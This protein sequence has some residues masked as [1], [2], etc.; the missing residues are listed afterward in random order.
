M[1]DAFNGTFFFELIFRSPKILRSSSSE[2]FKNKF[3][4][5]LQHFKQ[6]FI[7]QNIATESR[8]W[9]VLEI[10]SFYKNFIFI[11]NLAWNGKV[12]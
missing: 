9:F 4:R 7:H 1:I 2:N 10:F 11:S 12:G 5:T 8:R 3:I 6:E